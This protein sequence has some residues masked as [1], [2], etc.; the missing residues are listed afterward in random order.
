MPLLPLAIVLS[1]L[2]AGLGAIVPSIGDAVSWLAWVPL[3]GIV[4]VVSWS[5]SLSLA[6][7]PIP[8]LG[9]GAVLAIYAGLGLAIVSRTNPFFGPGLPI[10]DWVRR[11]LAV[12][13]ARVLVPGI[14]LPAV[15][16][17][18]VLFQRTAPVDQIRFLA[19]NGGDAALVTLAG[20]PSAYLAGTADAAGVARAV[21]PVLPLATRAIGVALLSVDDDA[22]LTDLTELSGRL[23]LQSAVVPTGGFSDV[24]LSRW[25]DAVAVRRIQEISVDPSGGESRPTVS[26]GGRASLAIYPLGGMPKQGRTA[27]LLPSLAARLTMGPAALVWVS[28]QP[29]D[30]AE[31]AASGV[32]LTAQVLKLVGRG[33]RWGLDAGFFQRVNPSIV[34]LPAGVASRFAKP[35]LG[36]LDLLA[37]R[38]VYRTDLDGTIVI[39]LE[40]D[41]MRVETTRG[42]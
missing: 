39:S 26:L 34:I 3:A 31:L 29:G 23:D 27:A 28:A 42:Q 13:P 21:D 7:L 25:R 36:T 24:A 32:P 16:L 35:T 37:N 41:G 30:Q 19:V 18:A 38:R 10:A 6:S 14:G 5:G 15:V 22:S 9:L 8:P 4:G 40:A 2:T 17:G 11:V 33:A 1:G 20:G 12:V